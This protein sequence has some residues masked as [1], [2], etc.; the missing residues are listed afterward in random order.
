MKVTNI[1]WYS[2]VCKI[3]IYCFFVQSSYAQTNQVSFE[4][5]LFLLVLIFGAIT[6]VIYTLMTLYDYKHNYEKRR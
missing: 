6:D 2:F 1:F 5:K 3:V 4:F